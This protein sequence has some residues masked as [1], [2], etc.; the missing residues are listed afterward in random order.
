[1]VLYDLTAPFPAGFAS[2][3]VHLKEIPLQSAK[4]RYTGMIYNIEIGSMYSTYIDFPGHI[5]ETDDGVTAENACLEDHYRVP[6]SLIRMDR[7]NCP[8][9]VSA[10]DLEM[11]F[12]GRVTTHSLMIHALG[13]ND[14][15]EGDRRVYLDDSAVDWIIGC[16]VRLLVSD[17]YESEALEGVFLKLFKAGVTCV[18]LPHGM[19][20]VPDR[21]FLLS[22]LFMNV[23]AV[24]QI[25][26]RILAECSH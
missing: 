23:P 2:E 14:P 10:R 18:C 21:E 26:C 16:G 3:K 11:A 1:M 25:P 6:C 24:T 17:I 19:S 9:G 15:A 8:G 7:E 4:T 22:V 12:G 20:R 5:R 13:K